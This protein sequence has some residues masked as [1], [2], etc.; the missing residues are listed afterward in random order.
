MPTLYRSPNI[1]LDDFEFHVVVR[2]TR[3]RPHVSYFWRPIGPPICAWESLAHWQGRLPGRLPKGLGLAFK[4]YRYSIRVALG[5]TPR[6][7][8]G[9][10]GD[11]RTW[12]A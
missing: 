10:R 11:K 1:R 2:T 8:G 7:P 9:T 6:S 3:G 4:P 12:A 5:K